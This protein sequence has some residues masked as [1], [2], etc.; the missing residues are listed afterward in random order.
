MHETLIRITHEL[1]RLMNV[2]LVYRSTLDAGSCQ[3]CT[4]S[5]LEVAD[6]LLCRTHP[7]HVRRQPP[8]GNSLSMRFIPKKLHAAAV[9]R[10][11][12]NLVPP[13]NQTLLGHDLSK[14][15]CSVTLRRFERYTHSACDNIEHE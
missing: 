8:V 6:R 5:T 4:Y 13:M 15:I 12:H 2:G 11:N 9:V 7:E 14:G 1:S 10:A 3:N